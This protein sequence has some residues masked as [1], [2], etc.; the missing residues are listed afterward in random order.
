MK[1]HI[2]IANEEEILSLLSLY[3]KNTD[4]RS[5][6][7]NTRTV[8]SVTPYPILTCIFLKLVYDIRIL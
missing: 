7:I 4:F 6:E 5:P 3:L 8:H 1:E 2:L